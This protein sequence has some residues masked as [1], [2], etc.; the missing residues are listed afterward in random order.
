V[1]IV[2]ISVK[3]GTVVPIGHFTVLVGPNNVGKS[4]TLR[5]IHNRMVQGTGARTTLVKQITFQKPQ[6][7]AELVAGL[8]IVPDPQNV[9]QHHIR[10]ITA[11]LKSGEALAI[12]REHL[13]TQFNNS[14]NLDFTLGNISKFRVSY[15]DAESRLQVAK[16]GAA[17]DVHTQ[18]PQSLLQALYG[19]QGDEEEKLCAVFRDTFGIDICLDYSGLT[20]MK[21]RVAREFGDIPEDPRKASPILANHAL[22]DEQ[23]DGF[24]SFV[25]VVLSLLLSAG[26]VVLLDEP[27]AF[28]HPAQA[29]QLGAWIGQHAD[30]VSGQVIVATHNADF[31]GGILSTNQKVDIFRLNRTGDATTFTRIPSRVTSQLAKTPILSSQRVQAAIFHKGVVVSEA[32]ADRAVYHATAVTGLQRQDILFVNAHNKQ[33]IPTVAGVLKEAGIPVAAIAD[34]DILN[35]GAD[36]KAC[37]EGLGADPDVEDIESRRQQVASAVNGQTEEHALEALK[38]DT[39]E[40]LRQLENNDHDLPGARGALARIRAGGSKWSALKLRGTSGAPCKVKRT[41][42]TLIDDLESHG[43]FVVPVGELESWIDLGTRRKNRWIILALDKLYADGPPAPLLQFIARI[44]RHLDEQSAA[45][46]SEVEQPG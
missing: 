28:L 36:L 43:L 24:R 18:P 1:K 31:L 30:N 4:Q 2:S 39:A 46:V 25:G 8:Q 38:E 26:R 9:Q 37:L 33:T 10:G 19:S 23:G 17:F 16:S 44:A 14:P 27:E 20:T 6:S 29:R 5:D 40:F 3:D 34:I 21:L 13:E 35:S 7:F 42:R 41:L 12:N 11:N 32:D 15:L 45:I 22:L